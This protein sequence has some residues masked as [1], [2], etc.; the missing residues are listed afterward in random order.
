V[1]CIA[2]GSLKELLDI[3]VYIDKVS[4]GCF[5]P[6]EAHNVT[7]T[8]G[9]SS[10]HAYPGG[11]DEPED[12]RHGARQRRSDH[13]EWRRTSSADAVEERRSTGSPN[14]VE[15]RRSTCTTDA[16]EVTAAVSS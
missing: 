12:G 9:C 11:S 16:L 3:S 7:Q 2:T 13:G 10:R 4:P 5:H 6:S 14:A 15:E 1:Y 8:H